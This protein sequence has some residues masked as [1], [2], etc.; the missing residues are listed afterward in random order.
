M[1]FDFNQGGPDLGHLPYLRIGR[2]S[3]RPRPT[4]PPRDPARE[5]SPHTEG[6]PWEDPGLQPSLT[7]HT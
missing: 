7:E 5:T 1:S 2:T 4:L 3:D 6:T